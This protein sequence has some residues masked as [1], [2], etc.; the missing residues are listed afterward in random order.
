MPEYGSWF[1]TCRE[2]TTTYVIRSI[3]W[4]VSQFILD[5]ALQIIIVSIV[6][7]ATFSMIMRVKR[8]TRLKHRQQTNRNDHQPPQEPQHQPDRAQKQH[9]EVT[10]LSEQPTSLSDKTQ[11]NQIEKAPNKDDSPTNRRSSPP[12]RTTNQKTKVY[13]AGKI[14]GPRDYG[15]KN[16]ETHRPP[17]EAKKKLN[18]M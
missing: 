14:K 5:N 1:M 7:F 18:K 17:V 2:K 6:T 13:D 10:E 16:N 11:N 12:K 3:V 8:I 15:P 9:L 4:L